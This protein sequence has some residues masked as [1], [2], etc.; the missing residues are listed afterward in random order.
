[1]DT[2]STKQP[3]KPHSSDHLTAQSWRHFDK[4]CLHTQHH[5]SSVTWIFTCCGPYIRQRRYF[6][7][8]VSTGSN[9]LRQLTACPLYKEHLW[10]SS[11]HSSLGNFH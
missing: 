3:K 7:T 9:C 11:K 2:V 10:S 6:S 4:M 8:L 5:D 1:M